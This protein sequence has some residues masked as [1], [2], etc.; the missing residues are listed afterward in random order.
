MDD[1]ALPSIEKAGMTTSRKVKVSQKAAKKGDTHEGANAKLMVGQAAAKPP[2]ALVTKSSV[3][4]TTKNKKPPPVKSLPS[5]EMVTQSSSAHC[6][7]PNP[8]TDVTMNRTVDTEV[9]R[10]HVSIKSRHNDLADA[11]G[12]N[13][14]SF[15]SGKEN[16]LEVEAPSSLKRPGQSE[17]PSA[18][19]YVALVTSLILSYTDCTPEKAGQ[20]VSD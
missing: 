15:L 11:I 5:T 10:K 14:V 16:V 18:P 12:T 4:H 3:Q 6:G 9:R 1:S 2:A 20:G 7:S 8:I 17:A 13:G 19:K